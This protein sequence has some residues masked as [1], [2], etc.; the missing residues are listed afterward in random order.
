MRVRRR[1]RRDGVGVSAWTPLV[2]VLLLSSCSSETAPG[3]PTPNT[4][5]QLNPGPAVLVGAGD[6]GLCGSPG[7]DGTARLLDDIPGTV[8]AAGDNAYPRGSATD[9]QN[10]YNPTWGRHL[11]RTRPVPGNHDYETPGAAGYFGYFGLRA[12]PSALGVN[13]YEVGPWLILALNSEIDARTS[14]AQLEFVRD[15]LSSTSARCTAAVF[16]RPLFSSG[17]NGNNLDMRDIWR[18]LYEFRV[19]IVLN[20]HDHLY[21]RFALQDPDGRP[22]PVTG[23][24]QFTVGTGGGTLTQPVTRRPNSDI[25]IT[26]TFGVLKLTLFD[27]GYQWD[28]VPVAGATSRDSG[29]GACH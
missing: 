6:I 15:Q 20:G 8:F 28:F 12:G 26:S 19:E 4:I 21:E 11:A 14:S 17:P 5:D 18:I 10:C 9:Y 7:P 16:H 1:A 24:R 3:A 13:A 23:I 27:G 25:I 2:L 22:D 29:L